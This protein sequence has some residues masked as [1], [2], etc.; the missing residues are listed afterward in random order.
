[1]KR[2]NEF[3]CHVS[4]FYARP[5]F[6]SKINVSANK[7]SQWN[8]TLRYGGSSNAPHLAFW[9]H[10]QPD[11]DKTCKLVLQ[12][13]RRKRRTNF[14]ENHAV[15]GIQRRWRFIKHDDNLTSQNTNL[16][17]VWMENSRSPWPWG[18]MC[19]SLAPRLLGLRIRI[20]PGVWMP[21][22]F[23]CCVLSDRGLCVGQITCPEESYRVSCVWVR[24]WSLNNEKALATRG[25]RTM[26][27]NG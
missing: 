25:C 1:M 24:F 19:G 22:S 16:E 27:K 11:G 3:G 21:V 14:C 4:L 17:N 23:K 6:H 2:R 5:Y 10:D 13:H 8:G 7:E 12:H 15:K 20:P 9:I 26:G 18:L